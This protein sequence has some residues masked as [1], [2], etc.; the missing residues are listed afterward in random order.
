[1]DAQNAQDGALIDDLLG[2]LASPEQMEMRAAAGQFQR[3]LALDATDDPAA[4]PSDFVI[5]PGGAA[6]RDRRGRLPT[7]F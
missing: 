1:V 2:W 6:V 4:R 3:A 7:G 5:D